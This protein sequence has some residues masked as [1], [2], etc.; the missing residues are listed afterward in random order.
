MTE[1]TSW[2]QIYGWIVAAAV[3]IAAAAAPVIL[4]HLMTKKQQF[5]Q[6][7]DAVTF[8][9]EAAKEEN[10]LIAQHRSELAAAQC[11]AARG[12]KLRS[13]DNRICANWYAADGIQGIVDAMLEAISAAL[14]DGM[15]PDQIRAA[16]VNPYILPIRMRLSRLCTELDKARSNHPP[17]VGDE[18]L[19]AFLCLEP[20]L[21]TDSTHDILQK[22]SRNQQTIRRA[23]NEEEYVLRYE[24]LLTAMTDV[25][26]GEAAHVLDDDSTAK[27]DAHAALTAIAEAVA[28][29]RKT[30]TR[31]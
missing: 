7:T 6:Q 29:L 2:L 4:K 18:D 3:I 14:A 11:A 9:R 12:V 20:L 13:I 1:Q 8:L 24:Q 5:Q 22:S 15:T 16:V 28:L 19:R 25:F 26:D 27:Q 31:P 17:T 10:D 30:Y 21:P 23:L